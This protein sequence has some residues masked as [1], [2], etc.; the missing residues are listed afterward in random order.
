M[1]ICSLDVLKKSCPNGWVR[2]LSQCYY[3]SKL[4][5][6]WHSANS[7]CHSLGGNLVVPTNGRVESLIRSMINQYGLH[8]PW[9]GLR[10]HQD[11]QFYTVYGTKPSYTDWAPGEPN[12]SGGNEDCAHFAF[13][14]LKWND[15]PCSH[16]YHFICKH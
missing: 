14:F 11:G 7:I 1:L 2:L 9:I 10:K 4:K 15:V 6:D 12:N 8:H 16:Q 5:T 13:S 3:F